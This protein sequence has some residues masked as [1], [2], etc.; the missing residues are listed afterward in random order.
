MAFGFKE[1]PKGLQTLTWTMV[2]ERFCYY[3]MQA[4]LTLYMVNVLFAHMGQ[5]ASG[6]YAPKVY[7]YFRGL[8]YLMPLLGGYIADR[9]WG[10]RACVYVGAVLMGLGYMVLAIPGLAPFYIALG[11]IVFGNGFFKPNATAMLGGFYPPGDLRRDSAFTLFYMGINLGA[12]FSPLICGGIA[13]WGAYRW[14]FL[15]AGV[16]MVFCLFVFWAGRRH[17]GEIGLVPAGRRQAHEKRQ[18]LTREERQEVGVI[19]LLTFFVMFFFM[20]FDQAGSSLTLL[21][22]WNMDRTIFGFT[23]PTAWFQSVNPGFILILGVPFSKLWPWLAKRGKNPSTPMK[24]FWGLVFAAL[25]T[26]L[27]IPAG[28][29]V[30]GG[31]KISMLWLV[32]CY[33]VFTVG[34]L[35]C[36]PIGLSMVTKL[37][38][39]KLVSLLMGVFFLAISLANMAAGQLASRLATMATESFF[40]LLTAITAVPAVVLLAFVKTLNRWSHGKA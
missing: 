25:A 8:V 7:G 24:M 36:S 27:M 40:L 20:T 16:C 22:E 4:I 3:G 6:A 15:V 39:A 23:I 34:E 17:L 1:H 33:F 12:F 32:F 26:A 13:D 31:N 29:I 28:Y 5:E 18:P 14:A 30:T 35:C 9:Y 38:P 19:L 11:I 21:A 2:G 37:S 10:Q